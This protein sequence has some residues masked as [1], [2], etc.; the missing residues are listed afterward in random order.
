MRP[1]V[2]DSTAT[3]YSCQCNRCGQL[4]CILFA[5][6]ARFLVYPDSEESNVLE[7]ASNGAVMALVMVG[8]IVANLVAFLAFIAFLNSMLLWFGSIVGLDFLSLEVS[9]TLGF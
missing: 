8:N 2:I 3:V 7:A 1:F 4:Y 5:Q 9:T 6:N